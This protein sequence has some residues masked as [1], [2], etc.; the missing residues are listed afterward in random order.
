M[1]V[2]WHPYRSRDGYCGVRVSHALMPITRDMG[3]VTCAKCLRRY[4]AWCDETRAVRAQTDRFVR[5]RV[6]GMTA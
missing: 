1:I 3:M 5:L 4:R 6:T 2:H